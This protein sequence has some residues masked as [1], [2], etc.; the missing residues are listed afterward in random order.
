MADSAIRLVHGPAKPQG[1]LVF[2]HGFTG[3]LDET[4]ER[5]PEWLD[6]LFGGR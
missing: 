4:W 2:V 1:T 3:G 5:F 6:A